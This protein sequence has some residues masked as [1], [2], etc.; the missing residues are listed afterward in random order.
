MLG[1]QFDV[2]TVIKW[3]EAVFLLESIGVV[4]PI[5]IHLSWP[6]ILSLRPNCSMKMLEELLV[7][8][9]ITV[10]R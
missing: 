3:N 9:A 7:W 6:R 2:F 4:K 1:R 10:C 5:G 8:M